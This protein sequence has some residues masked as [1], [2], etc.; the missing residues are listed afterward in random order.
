MAYESPIRQ[1]LGQMQTEIENDLIVKVSQ[2]V[3][4][5]VT[6]YYPLTIGMS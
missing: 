1:Y 3:G 5:I 2:A 4:W 6:S